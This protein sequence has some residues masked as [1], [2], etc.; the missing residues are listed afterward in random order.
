MYIQLYEMKRTKDIPKPALMARDCIA[1]RMRLLNR[2]ITGVYD[3]ALR[4]LGVKTSQLNILV[5]A[6]YLGLARPAEICRRLKMDL[7]TLSR[8]VERMR[9]R[10]WIEV[11]E[12]E[13]DARAHPFRVSAKGRRL[14]EKAFPAWERAQQK[15]K[16][17][18]GRSEAAALGKAAERLGSLG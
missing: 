16:D 12:D 13:K 3:D 1:V 11:R 6:A 7:S 14:L 10:G 9:A 5:A 18:L 4:P 17:L 8:N 2:V 15:A